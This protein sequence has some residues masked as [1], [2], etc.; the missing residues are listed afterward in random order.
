MSLL[1]A[2]R[3]AG[4]FLSAA[5]AEF[6]RLTAVL[7]DLYRRQREQG[8]WNGYLDEHSRQHCID[9]QVRTFQW[10]KPFLPERGVVLDWGCQHA[11]D[12]CL[13]RAAF[14]DRFEQHACD[15]GPP[16]KYPVFADFAEARFSELDDAVRTPYAASSFDVVIGSGV[17][18]HVAMD[19]ESLKE[20]HRILKPDG[21]FIGTYLPNRW[22]I[23]EWRRRVVQKRDFH[24][25]LYN[26]RETIDLLKHTGFSP[27]CVDHHTFIWDRVL[28]KLVAR[29][30]TA[31][32]QVMKCLLPVHLFCSTLR[33]AARKVAWF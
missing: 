23:A 29:N 19:Y 13:L 11:P 24:Q 8:T 14:G 16:R 5:P 10:Y 1:S 21:I 17:L 12:S 2:S 15:F 3:L 28:A 33:F 6:Q 26:R 31:F 27:I 9:N 7:R 22:S 4:L 18:E 30:S 32:G 20:L 25:R